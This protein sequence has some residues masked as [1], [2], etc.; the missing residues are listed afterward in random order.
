MPSVRMHRTDPFGH[1]AHRM[2][3]GCIPRSMQARSGSLINSVRSPKLPIGSIIIVLLR[4]G[5]RAERFTSE[6]ELDTVFAS[7]VRLGVGALLVA[8]EPAYNRWLRHDCPQTTC[9]ISH[10][11]NTHH[12]RVTAPKTRRAA[13]ANKLA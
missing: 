9:Q 5:R 7:L 6:G 10:A 1:A 8:Q 2:R 12:T 4:R 11:K 3:G 13:K